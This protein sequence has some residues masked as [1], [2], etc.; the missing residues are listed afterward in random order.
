MHGI[1]MD[2]QDAR[3]DAEAPYESG[4]H[5]AGRGAAGD[6]ETDILAPAQREDSQRSDGVVDFVGHLQHPLHGIECMGLCPL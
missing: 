5:R 3:L 1:L 6:R 4:Q 2:F